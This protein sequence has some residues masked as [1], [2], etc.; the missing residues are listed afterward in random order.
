[1]WSR[2]A[3]LYFTK[4][5]SDTLRNILVNLAYQYMNGPWRLLW[6]KLGYDP[7]KDPQ[8]RI[9]QIIDFRVRNTGMY[10]TH[11]FVLFYKRKLNLHI[12]TGFIKILFIFIGGFKSVLKTYRT[13]SRCSMLNK[14]N[15]RKT[16]GTNV[17]FP[18]ESKIKN[19]EENVYLL[20]PGM[21]PPRRQMFYQVIICF[22]FYFYI[23]F[24]NQNFIQY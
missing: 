24:K 14:S 7:R 16:E 6:I 9:Y 19:L 3:L 2:L 12:I 18:N 13:K 5:S 11:Y 20:K 17:E 10:N 21:L 1:M 22:F 8:S 23:K 15:I 4:L